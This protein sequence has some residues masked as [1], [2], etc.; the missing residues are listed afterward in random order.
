MAQFHIADIG[1]T[2]ILTV[3][4]NGAALDISAA[5]SL[6][7]KVERPDGTSFTKTPTFVTDG[8]NGKVQWLTTLAGDLSLEGVYHDQVSFTLSGWTGKIEKGT[9]QVY[10]VVA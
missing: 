8:S 9:F 3:K 5:T 7:V 4:E 1:A 2:R 10:P 6:S